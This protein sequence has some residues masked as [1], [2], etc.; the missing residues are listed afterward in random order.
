VSEKETTTD[1]DYTVAHLRRSR[2]EECRI[3]EP[4]PAFSVC[5]VCRE[6]LRV[7]ATYEFMDGRFE[8]VT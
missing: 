2:C 5:K 1:E 8:R 6:M 7:M 3:R 4:M